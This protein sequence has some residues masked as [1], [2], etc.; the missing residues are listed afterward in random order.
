VQAG[1]LKRARITSPL[2]ITFRDGGSWLLE[3]ARL[4]LKGA[5][6][7]AAAV[8]GQSQTGRRMPRPVTGQP[9]E[10][11]HRQL[12]GGLHR[13]RS[14]RRQRL[15]SRIDAKHGTVQKNQNISPNARVPSRHRPRLRAG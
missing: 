15:S 7:L 1:E 8:S 2:T 6:K 10:W 12:T 4:D 14:R 13:A 3:V 9:A 5:K 11:L